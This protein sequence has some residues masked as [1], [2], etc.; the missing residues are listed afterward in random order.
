VNKLEILLC[1]QKLINGGGVIKGCVVHQ[2]QAVG[3]G[4]AETLQ[5]LK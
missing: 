3:I 1:D 4:S 2:P 5:R